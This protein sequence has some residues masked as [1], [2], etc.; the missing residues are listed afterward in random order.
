MFVVILVVV[1]IQFLNYFLLRFLSIVKFLTMVGILRIRELL[2]RN[3]FLVERIHLNI[4]TRHT[5]T[6][7]HFLL[8]VLF[9]F[10]HTLIAFLVFLRV[11]FLYSKKNYD[12]D[13]RGSFNVNIVLTC[14]TLLMIF[15]TP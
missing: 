13:D 4:F 14:V 2:K 5:C 7:L 9:N 12:D 15:P 11:L 10:H 3:D 1:A 8:L 6:P